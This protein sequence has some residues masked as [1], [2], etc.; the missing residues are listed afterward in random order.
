MMHYRLIAAG[1]AAGGGLLTAAFLQA[2]VAVAGPDDAVAPSATGADAF[3]I[4]GFTFDPFTGSGSSAAEGFSLV[5]PLTGSA[6]LLTLGGGSPGGVL[7]TAPQS[8]DVFGADGTSLG[9]IDSSVVVTNLAGFTNTEFTVTDATAADDGSATDLPV[10]GS[11][12]DVFNLGGGF[13]NVYVATPGEDGTVTDTFVTPWGSMDLSS[14]F[15]GINAADPLQPGDAFSALQ[16][17]ASGGGD[18]AFAIGGLTLD[19][20][21]GTGDS[22]QEG[23]APITALGGAAPFLAIGG[24]SL[25]DPSHHGNGLASQDFNVFSGTGDDA[26]QI[27]TI[28]TAVD[29]TNLLGMT[30]TQLVVTDGSDTGDGIPAAGTIYDAFNF[31]GGFTNVYV[32]TPGEDGTITDT[33]V[34]PFGSMDLSSLFSGMG[35]GISLDPGAAFGALSDSAVGE[36]AFTIGDT[37]FDPFTG[38]GADTTPGFAPVFQTVGALPLL[39]IGG[40]TPGLDLGGTFFPLPITSQDFNIYDGTDLIGTAHAQETVT[41][42]LGLTTT[43]F[44]IDGVTPGAGDAADLP[45]LGSVYSVLNLGG[46][47]ANVYSAI[48]GLDGGDST[49]SD[50]LVTPFGDFDLSSLFGGFDASALMDPGAAF[51]GLDF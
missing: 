13:A 20:F 28:N 22:A 29:V 40:G 25:G 26:T 30:N 12:Y 42:L 19:P 24:A 9:S 6:P 5:H 32:A 47:F 50:V 38:S 44:V 45:E 49:V 34:T 1:L 36:D 16:A 27:G 18:D 17:G 15:A 51:L 8:F 41:Q 2:A 21:T 11:V 46:G 3:T 14:M 7:P 4:G 33:F 10:V 35:G 43:E 48:P 37:T 31:G 23:F 39:N